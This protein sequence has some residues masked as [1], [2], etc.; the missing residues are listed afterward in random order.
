MKKF[1]DNHPYK[2]ILFAGIVLAVVINLRS[3]GGGISKVFS[4]LAPV[5]MGCFIAYLLNVLVSPIENKFLARFIKPERTVLKR[6]LAIFLSLAAIIVLLGLLMRVVIPQFVD[7]LGVFVNKLPDIVAYMKDQSSRYAKLIP[8]GEGKSFIDNLNAQNIMSRLEQLL[9]YLTSS[10]GNVLKSVFGFGVSLVLGMILAIYMVA[11]KEML[12]RQFTALGRRYLSDTAQKR[13]KYVLSVFDESFYYFLVGQFLDACILGILCVT[14]LMIFKFPYA[15]M[16]GT[17]VGVTALIPLLGAYI[18][19]A[20]GFLMTLTVNPV[21][22]LL[23]IVFLIFL[24]QLEDNLIYPK[25][26]GKTIGLPGLWVFASVVVGGGFFG[27]IGVF[28]AVP[29]VSAIYKILGNS[30]HNVSR[31]DYLEHHERRHPSRK[32]KKQAAL[33]AKNQADETQ[34]SQTQESETETAVSEETEESREPEEKP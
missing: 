34:V 19:G 25:I 17:V 24:K 3:V 30:I 1:W 8:G 32:A 26:V 4:I 22:A 14:G 23:F 7:S 31:D 18:G 11:S 12:K 21:K 27:V 20:F 29:T 10:G 13:W 2:V 15:V 9:R 5:F 33:A 6:G 16:I 28:L